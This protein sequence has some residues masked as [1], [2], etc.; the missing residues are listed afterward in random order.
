MSEDAKSPGVSS[1]EL[2]HRRPISNQL[3]A[4][5]HSA[6]AYVDQATDPSLQIE[7]SLDKAIPQ[8]LDAT[9]APVYDAAG[10]SSVDPA[11]DIA[12][13]LAIASTIE[14]SPRTKRIQKACDPCSKRKVKVSQVIFWSGV[15][16]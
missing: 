13:G 4:H 7:P 2:P 10:P 15:F 3:A 14:D 9:S 16:R 6:L 11:A 8:S 5:A 1:P 12:A